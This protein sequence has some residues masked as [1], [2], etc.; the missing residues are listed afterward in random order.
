MI[1][2][3][4]DISLGPMSQVDENEDKISTQMTEKMIDKIYEP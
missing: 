1:V 3:M 2:I 4:F